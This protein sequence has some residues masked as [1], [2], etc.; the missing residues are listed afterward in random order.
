M[1]KP[2]P[3]QPCRHL[4]AIKVVA[5]CARADI[6]E[7]IVKNARATRIANRCPIAAIEAKMGWKTAEQ[8]TNEVPAQYMDMLSA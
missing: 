8:S 2:P 6:I 1:I 4:P 5:L 3:P 7:P